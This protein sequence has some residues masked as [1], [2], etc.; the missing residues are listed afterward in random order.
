MHLSY[1]EKLDLYNTDQIVIIGSGIV[2]LTSAIYLKQLAPDLSVLM[3]ERGKLPLGASTKN[4]GFACFGSVSEI[5]EDL[6]VMPS[7]EVISLI[8]NRYNGLQRLMSIVADSEIEFS[9]DGG[10]EVFTT[11]QEELY[12]KCMTNIPMCCD[13][14]S[15]AIGKNDAYQPI[16]LPIKIN[17]ES[18]VIYNPYEG[19]L[20][21]M[22]MV[23][24]LIKKAIS[25]GVRIING[26][27]VSRVD[28]NGYCLHTPEGLKVPYSKLLVC[29]NGFASR[30]IKGIE[31][32]PVRN[33]V[34]MTE[35][36]NDLSIKGCFHYNKGYVY[37][38]D[39]GDRILLGGGRNLALE[40]ETTDQFGV[41]ETIQSYLLNFL[42]EVLKVDKDI[43]IDQWWSG[44]LG[45]GPTKST[46]IEEFTKDHF[47]GVRMGGMGVALGSEVGYKL[48]SMVVMK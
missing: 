12:D 18:R 37:F 32:K 13:L 42:T 29:T 30:L 9:M 20:N 38:R 14:V 10:Y 41:T 31:V 34:L 47:M 16:S 17:C 39:Y 28:Y 15:E 48:A 7:S 2:G 23:R 24:S 5:L 43:K 11:D 46:I 40:K 26:I 21:P 8:R 19:K 4:A 44:I 33:Q 6:K 27:E 22:K 1:W 45:V 36:I 25:A 35:P 3:I